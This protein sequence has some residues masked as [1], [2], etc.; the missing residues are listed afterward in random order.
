M[1]FYAVLKRKFRYKDRDS[2]GGLLK[3]GPLWDFNLCFGNVDYGPQECWDPTKGWVYEGDRIF[4]F[5]RLMEDPAFTAL[6]HS[7]WSL[8]RSGRLSD[9]SVHGLID[10]LRTVLATPQIRNFQRWPVL[11]TYI[12]PNREVYN[13]WE[14]EVNAL[15]AW[16]D[17]RLNFMDSQYLTDIPTVKDDAFHVNVFPNP[18]TDR[19]G[20]YINSGQ[21]EQILLDIY[22]LNGQRILSIKQKLP[23]GGSVISWDGRNSAGNRVS[24]GVYIYRLSRESRGPIQGKIVIQ[25]N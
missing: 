9:N 21:P 3:M 15:S 20:F 12:W 25:K 10:S 22:N 16:I 24:A 8:A 1:K 2:N 7:R 17:S 4:W 23:T 11:G 14:E 5:K 18:F 6:V 13:T 19:T